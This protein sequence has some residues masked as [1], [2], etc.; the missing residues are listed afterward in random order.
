MIAQITNLLKSVKTVEDVSSRGVQ[1]VETTIGAID[2]DLAIFE[3]PESPTA[4]ATAE[5]L[6]AVSK[7]VTQAVTKAVAAANSAQPE[8]VAAAA[9]LARKVVAEML[10]TCK[11]K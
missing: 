4:E 2:Q 9:N 6:V 11:V 7:A 8:Q 10:A 5:D 3:S 1:A